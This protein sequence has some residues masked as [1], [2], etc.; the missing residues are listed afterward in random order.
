MHTHEIRH[1]GILPSKMKG[2]TGWIIHIR[3]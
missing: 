2:I 3:R 1:N